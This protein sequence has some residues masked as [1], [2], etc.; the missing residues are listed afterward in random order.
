MAEVRSRLGDPLTTAD[1]GNGTEFWAYTTDANSR[2]ASMTIA[3]GRMMSLRL[4][5]LGAYTLTD[6]SGVSIGDDESAVIRKRGQPQSRTTLQDHAALVYSV[7][8]HTTNAYIFVDGKVESFAA[9]TTPEFLK[10]LPA[11]D[12]PNIPD[13]R[14]MESAIVD[15]QTTD[16]S[17]VDWEYL[18]LAVHPC[19]ADAHWKM[20]KQSLLHNGPQMFDRLDAVCQPTGATRTF[21]FDITAGYGK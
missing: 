21:F 11:V 12:L 9:W 17:A 1:L 16:K 18:Y 3:S 13:G 15:G 10:S 7:D 6:P 8:G 4:H 2:A 14:S 19:N 5:A 20:Q